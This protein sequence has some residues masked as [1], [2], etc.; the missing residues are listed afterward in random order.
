MRKKEYNTTWSELNLAILMKCVFIELVGCD[1][2]T[3]IAVLGTINT[4]LVSQ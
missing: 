2:P 4:R 1:C 3:A